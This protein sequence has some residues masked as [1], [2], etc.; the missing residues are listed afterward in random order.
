M[1]TI[2]YQAPSLFVAMRR[3]RHVFAALILRTMRTRF[4]GHGLGY[5]FAVGWPVS[6]ILILIAI[7]SISHRAAPFGDSVVLFIATGSIPFMVFSYLARFMMV[8]LIA[9]KPLLALPEVKLVDVLIAVAVLEMLSAFTVTIIMIILGWA[10]DIPIVPYDIAEAFFALCA[11]VILGLGMGVLNSVIMMMNQMWMTGYTLFN[12][13][14][15]AASGVAFVPSSVPDPYRTWLSYNPAL[16]VVE[17]MRSAYYRGYGED[18]LDRSY[19]IEFG[20]VTLGLG[21]I[22]E[23]LTRGYILSTR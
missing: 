8:D 11:A 17:W 2:Q 14:M 3:Q 10:F 1:S 9:N 16:Q 13:A 20:I 6:H 21:L 22:L 4:F 23:R 12:I 7:M 15:W 18:L 19:A 5:I